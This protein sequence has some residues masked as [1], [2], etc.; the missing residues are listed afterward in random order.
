MKYILDI[1]SEVYDYYCEDL[2]CQYFKWRMKACADLRDFFPFL[3]EKP[4]CTCKLKL[5]SPYKS[6]TFLAHVLS[7]HKCW[8]YLSSPRHI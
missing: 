4:H 2:L 3:L 7:M 1:N 5:H 8:L 6:I